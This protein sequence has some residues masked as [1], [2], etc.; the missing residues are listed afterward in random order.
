LLLPNPDLTA[1]QARAVLHF[2]SGG[3]IVIHNDPD[4]HWS[5]TAGTDAA[6]AAF[7]KA[8]RPHVSDA[9]VHVTGGPEGRYAMSYENNRQLIVAVTN[10]FGWVQPTNRNNIPP[11]IN[12]PAPPA[13]GVQVAWRRPLRS[14]DPY[15]RVRAI[16]AITKVRL[17]IERSPGMYRVSLPPFDYMA[18]LVVNTLPG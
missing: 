1:A 16:E 11:V 17:R 3:G 12:S 10:D 8:I 2:T 14:P 9:P 13:A 6:A 18:L 4:W 5:D 7:R 15:F